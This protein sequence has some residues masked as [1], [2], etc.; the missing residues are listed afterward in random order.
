MSEGL[1]RIR[2]GRKGE[3]R[4]NAVCEKLH[5]AWNSDHFT[6]SDLPFLILV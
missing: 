2:N 3:K 5:F 1:A 4:R 6:V